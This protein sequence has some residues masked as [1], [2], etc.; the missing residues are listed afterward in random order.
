MAPEYERVNSASALWARD[1]KDVKDEEYKEFYKHVSMDF[2]DPLA[3]V[4]NK[5]EGNQSYTSLLYIPRKAPFDLY[6]R[7]HKRGIKLYVKR[8]FIMDDADQLMPTYLRFVKGVIDSD[9]LPLNVSREILQKN[10]VIDRIRGASV[11]KILGLLETMAKD[12]PED[13]ALFWK[14]FGQVMKEG[15]IED[16]ANKERIAKLLRFSSTE[17]GS[18]EQTVSLDDY[19]SR[20]KE[21]QDKIYYITADN[22]KAAKKQSSSRS[23]PQKRHRSVV[24]E[25]SCR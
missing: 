7:E 24:V 23:F 15:P 9:D 21:G 19:V 17:T 10:K 13:Y 18:E 16:Y 2:E 5:V 22:F 14:T 25:R 4:H 12:Q 20:M 11:K 3:W 8:I 1:R 6:D